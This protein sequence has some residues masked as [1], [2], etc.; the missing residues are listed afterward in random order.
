MTDSQLC[1]RGMTTTTHAF[2]IACFPE[3]QNRSILSY[4]A[5]PPVFDT[6]ID[7]DDMDCDALL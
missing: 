1:P 6:S 4:S 5:Q 2:I 3:R 7:M